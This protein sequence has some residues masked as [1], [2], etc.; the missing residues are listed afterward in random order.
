MCLDFVARLDFV[1]RL[2][3]CNV[4]AIL[5]SDLSMSDNG[6]QMALDMYHFVPRSC[7]ILIDSKIVFAY[8]SR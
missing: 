4:L 3:F 5:H 1:M 8:T 6:K 7:A 2:K